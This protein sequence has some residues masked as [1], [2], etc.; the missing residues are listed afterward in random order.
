MASEALCPYCKHRLVDLWEVVKEDGDKQEMEC[1]YCE[2]IIIIEMSVLV[3]Y[4]A[5][6][7]KNDC[8]HN[9]TSSVWCTVCDS[10]TK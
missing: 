7:K 2:N 4:Y 6:K 9:N 3:S 10:P 5:Y 8:D 1:S